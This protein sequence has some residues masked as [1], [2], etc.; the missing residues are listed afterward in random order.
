MHTTDFH[1]LRSRQYPWPSYPHKSDRNSFEWRSSQFPH[2]AFFIVSPSTF[3]ISWRRAICFSNAVLEKKNRRGQ[4]SNNV[5]KILQLWVDSHISGEMRNVSSLGK[6]TLSDPGLTARSGRP[7]G[8]K[9]PGLSPAPSPDRGCA[10][11][12]PRARLPAPCSPLPSASAAGARVWLCVPAWVCPWV[13]DELESYDW[14]FPSEWFW[15]A[16]H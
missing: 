15:S 3:D 13:G 1:V 4:I 8:P 9:S 6:P 12:G 11:R 16:I 5:F 2:R 14:V 10:A 7:R